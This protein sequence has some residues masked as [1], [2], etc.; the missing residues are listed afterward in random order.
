M[1]R[2]YPVRTLPQTLQEMLMPC[3]QFDALEAHRQV[4]REQDVDS[5]KST[6]DDE[7]DDDAEDAGDP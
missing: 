4:Q 3:P 6:V 1:A 5:D 7:D 2:G